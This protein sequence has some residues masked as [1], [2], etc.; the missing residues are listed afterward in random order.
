LK[1]SVIIP[2]YN[3]EEYLAAALGSV[4]AQTRPLDEI[5]V[6]DDGSTDS[7][8]DILRSFGDRLSVFRQQNGGVAAAR[9]TGLE[10]ASGDLI[11]F[12]DQDD[13]WP[14]DRTQRLVEALESEPEAELA[15]GKVEICYQRDTP[16]DPS[17]NMETMHREF[18][19]GSMLVRAGLFP[20]LGRFNTR[21]GY[22]D[23]TEFW[24]RRTESKVRTL[25][26]EEVTLV[27]R[28]HACN[29]SSD[30]S[31]SKFHLLSA[32]RESLRRRRAK[33]VED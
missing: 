32:L 7:S 11:T 2:V 5:I 19:L 22:A 10:R 14:A 29:T 18:L 1:I 6:I 12:L 20:R 17:E 24:M 16:P 21:I 4:L 27:Y 30:Q 13:L 26:V 3:G 28:L 33:P 8:P 9:N 23:D 15:V 25:Y 31:V